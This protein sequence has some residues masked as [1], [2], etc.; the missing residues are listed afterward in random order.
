MPTWQKKVL[1]GDVFRNEDMTFEQRR[2]V[3]VHR[4]R[5]SGWIRMIG[6]VDSFK[7]M[8][9]DE[10]FEQ[11]GE[12]PEPDDFD[13]VWDEIYNQADWD[14]VWIDTVSKPKVSLAGDG[15]GGATRSAESPGATTE[16]D[17]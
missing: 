2:D 4:L 13:I 14:R 17:R 12:A 5:G 15:P 9:L 6:G 11:L 8:N 3:I 1:L 16:V 7:G 10:L